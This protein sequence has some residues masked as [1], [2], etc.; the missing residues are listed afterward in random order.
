MDI[1]KLKFRKLRPSRLIK[2][3]WRTG[4]L[5]GTNP[6]ASQ[7]RSWMWGVDTSAPHVLFIDGDEAAAVK[8]DLLC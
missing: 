6:S 4:Q 1:E 5:V 7:A 3:G 2:L 8:N